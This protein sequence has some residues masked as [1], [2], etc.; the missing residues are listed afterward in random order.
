MMTGARTAGHSFAR[1]DAGSEMAVDALVVATAVRL[2]GGIA[3]TH[4]PED[5]SAF[6]ARNPNVANPKV[7]PSWLLSV[8]RGGSGVGR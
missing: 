4:D 5:L 6:A 1:V 8:N 7:V 3:V 2:G